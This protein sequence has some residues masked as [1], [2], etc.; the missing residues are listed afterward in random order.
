MGSS[1][2]DPPYVTQGEG[3]DGSDPQGNHPISGE[4]GRSPLYIRGEA[5]KVPPHRPPHRLP[6]EGREVLGGDPGSTSGGLVLRE[7]DVVHAWWVWVDRAAG[8]RVRACIGADATEQ[9][10]ATV[11][12]VARLVR[13]VVPAGSPF[14]LEG[15]YVEPHRKGRRVNPQSV[16]PLAESAGAMNAILGPAVARP[17]EAQWTTRILGVHDTSRCVDVARR[18]RWPGEGWAAVRALTD[19]ERGALFEA[20]CIAA[21]PIPNPA[22]VEAR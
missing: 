2:E 22:A 3:V 4:V 18:L 21:W 16:I 6:T 10:V 20:A 14:V 1:P 11:A 12:D 9:V 17:M 7:L 19:V 5:D 13:A 15:L 8:L